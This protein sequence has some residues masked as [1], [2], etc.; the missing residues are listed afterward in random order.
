MNRRFGPGRALSLAITLTTATIGGL[1]A[2]AMPTAALAGPTP[3]AS[4]AIAGYARVQFLNGVIGPTINPSLAYNS[5]SSDAADTV[6]VISLGTGQDA[7]TFVGMGSIA[8]KSVVQVSSDEPTDNCAIG[9]WFAQGKDLQA[10]VDCFDLGGAAQDAGFS[11]IVTHPSS[12]PHG[13]FDY[14]LNTRANTS[15]KLTSFQFNS[16]H[17]ANSIR[18]LGT[19]KYQL[20]LGG[21]KTTGTHGVVKLSAYGDTPG[22]CE[23]AG[24]KGS[25]TGV[26]VK[27]NCYAVGN[28]PTDRDFVVTYATANSVMGINGQ[29]VANALANGKA[30]GYEPSVQFDSVKGARVTVIHLQTGIYEVFPAGSEGNAAKFAGNA[31]VNAVGS[32][33]QHCSV[34]GWV[35]QL[36]PQ[37]DIECRDAHGNSSDSAF[38]AEWV[39]P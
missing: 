5:L 17:K 8:G 15:G 23:L 9:T 30:G 2:I 13:T 33:G 1:G 11:L 39:V 31:Q 22:D 25:G 38:T 7:V 18:H 21:P 26:L 4:S 16:A 27:V 12:S 36:T 19:G 6:S 24:W 3:S 28:V 37:I 32:L 29:V 10:N 35:Q 14:S 34:D 20:T